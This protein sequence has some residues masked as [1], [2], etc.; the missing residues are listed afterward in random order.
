MA[1]SRVILPSQSKEEKLKFKFITLS[2]KLWRLQK[3]EDYIFNFIIPTNGRI[4]VKEFFGTKL[5][6]PTMLALGVS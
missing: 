1:N 5:G 4:L 3:F 2:T 6:V